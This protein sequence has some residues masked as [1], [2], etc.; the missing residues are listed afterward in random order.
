MPK[1]VERDVFVDTGRLDPKFESA[2]D[3]VAVEAFEYSAFARLA[4]EAE[5][6]VADWDEGFGIG[7]FC[8]D[9]DALSSLLVVLD[10]A[11]LELKDVAQSKAREAGEKGSGLEYGI[12]A[13]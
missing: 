9:A 2:V 5:C 8:F 7:L 12:V 6:L 1:A 11:P 13:V 10:M 4:A 3:K